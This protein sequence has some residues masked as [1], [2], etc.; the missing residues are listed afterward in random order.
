MELAY[1]EL[2]RREYELTKH[3]S[4]LQLDPLALLE[5]RDDRHLHGGAA[6]GALRH[7]RPRA[8]LPPPAVGRGEH[9]CVTGP[10]T[11]VNCT[12]TLLQSSIRTNPAL[13]EAAT[14]GTGSDDPRF[15]D[16]F[17]GVESIVTSTGRTTAACSNATCGRA[18]LPFEA[19]GAVSDWRLEL[20]ATCPSSTTTRS[21]T[22]S[23]TCATPRARAAPGC[24][25]A[26]DAR[27]E[28]RRPRT[29][30]S[31]R[32][33][34]VRHEFPPSGRRCAATPPAG[35]WR[36]ALRLPLRPEHYPFWSTVVG[37]IALRRIEFFAAPGPTTPATVMVFDGA[38]VAT[39]DALT[40]D[41]TLGGLQ[42]GA[43]SEPLPPA[44]GEF[45]RF[46]DD[47]SM[48]DLG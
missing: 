24:R 41:P 37:P 35:P 47:T 11:G 48:A 36:H 3:V 26:T 38:D 9:P 5:L 18:L 10:Y 20:P 21:P 14:R 15:S 40:V 2:N 42:V 8:L 12:L 16:H 33:L 22:S 29:V 45:V 1:H 17:G 44:V 4:L 6:G 30:G 46:F 32:L 19:S 27:G 43:L 25:R 28:T 31:V 23:C 13:G 7:G 34:S 39:G